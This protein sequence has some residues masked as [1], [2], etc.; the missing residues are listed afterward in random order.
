MKNINKHYKTLEL[1]KIFTLLSQKCASALA[2]ERALNIKPAN[3]LKTAQ[4]YC[5]QTEDAYILTARFG[6]PSFSA[7]EDVSNALRRAQAGGLLNMGELLSVAGVLR[8]IRM[9]LEWRAH[10]EGVETSLDEMFERLCKNK[11]LEDT[12]T[13][14]IISEEEMSDNA[15]PELFN[16]RRKIIAESTKIR[17]KLDSMIHSQ[18]YLKYLQDPV[19]T[20]R[21]GRYVVPVKSE[22]RSNVAGLVH[23]TSSSGSTVFI[24]PMSVVEAN[25]EI[26]MLKSKEADEIERILYELSSS[27]AEFADSIIDSTKV[28]VWLDLIF[29]KAKLA[30]DMKASVP[31]LNDKGVINLHKARHPLLSKDSVVPVSVTLGGEFDTMIITGPNTGGKT[32]TLKSIG[33]ITLMAMSGL[34]I[35]CADNSDVCVFEKIFADIGDEQSIEQSLSTFSSHM[36]NTISIMQNANDRSLVLLDE[37][38]SGTDPI[39]GAALA[40]AIIEKLRSLGVVLATT[41]HYAELK[42]YALDTNGVVNA[43]CEFDVQTL[44]PTYK[45]QIGVPGR[46][47]AFAISQRLGMEKSVVQNAKSMVSVD[48]N[49]FERVVEAL[50]KSR[51]QLENERETANEERIKAQKASKEAKEKLEQLKTEYDKRI[52]QANNDARI[53]ADNARVEVNRILTELEKIKKSKTADLSKAKAAAKRGFSKLDEIG[54]KGERFDDNYVLPRELVVGDEVKIPNVS[55]PATVLRINKDS[56]IVQAGIM[57]RKVSISEVRLVEKDEKQK[58]G[59]DKKRNANYKSKIEQT[60]SRS[61]SMEYDIRGMNVEEAT[62]ELDR[63]IDSAIIN[64]QNTITIIHGKGTGVLRSGVHAY[65]KRHK[66]VRVFRLGTFGEGESGVTVVDLK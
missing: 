12:I 59:A 29:A 5:K 53:I 57:K 22:F 64:G 26:K 25:N 45:L 37:L 41:T 16:I 10:S 40:T 20:Q 19:V 23:D 11:Y 52:E 49:R 62:L 51:K 46:S 17:E 43:C 13:N 3:D 60:A 47:N 39:E 35:P 18:T 30:F 8:S 7:V 50:E 38:C 42:A 66:A 65:L 32:V 36:K 31:V 1:D 6:S 63:F 48:D 55:E 61:A 44:S 27:A 56:V 15:S 58:S 21:D 33:L 9:L 24:E 54:I 4:K 34:M 2:K 14:A 28:M